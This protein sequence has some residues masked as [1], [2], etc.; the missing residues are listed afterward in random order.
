MAFKNVLIKGSYTVLSVF[1]DKKSRLII[2]T[3]NVFESPEMIILINSMTFQYHGLREVIEV[4]SFAASKN[5]I[6]ESPKKGDTFFA[7]IPIN[8][9]DLNQ[10]GLFTFNGEA[11][12]CMHIDLVYCNN[13]YYRYDNSTYQIDRTLDNKKL[14]DVEFGID[15]IKSESDIL[16]YAY[17]WLKS[18]SIIF[19]NAEDC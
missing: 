3:A 19:K 18:N 7:P 6:P 16:A 10:F 12:N 17:K 8:V 11:W 1:Y 15:R 4:A 2:I 9:N 5:D 13:T 14:W